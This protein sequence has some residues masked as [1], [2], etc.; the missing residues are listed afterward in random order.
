M[1]K[2]KNKVG[3]PLKYSSPEELETKIQEYYKWSADNDKV[4]TVTGLC[5]YLDIERA[6]LIK[7]ENIFDD[8]EY[9]GLEEDVKKEMLLIIK[10]AKRRIE[11]EY[12]QALFNKS[13]CRGAMFVLMNNYSNY[14]DKQSIEQ[15]TN[16][17]SKL[18]LSGL[19]TEDLKR[20]LEE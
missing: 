19:S 5:M 7:Y 2:G 11:F 15:T 13:S 14:A 20:L 9:K 3:R 10:R 8:E 1:A 12:E 4:I 6:T 18:D 16:T 17:V